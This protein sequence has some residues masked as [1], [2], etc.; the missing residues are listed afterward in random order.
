MR[1]PRRVTPLVAVAALI[2]GAL[3]LFGLDAL[4]G[5]IQVA[6]LLCCALAALIAMK[7]GHGFTA[8]EFL[9]PYEFPAADIAAA[10]K[11]HRLTQALF[12][13]P[14]GDW[15]KGERGLAALPGREADFAAA[16]DTA[17]HYAQ[18]L[19]CRRIHAMSG[20]ITSGADLSLMRRTYI[21]NLKRAADRTA[22]DGLTLCLEPINR[23]DIPGYFLNTTSEA[24]A[25]IGDAS[26][27]IGLTPSTKTRAGTLA[28]KA[29]GKTVSTNM[30]RGDG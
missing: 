3:A 29:T 5:P 21:D 17:R 13:L 19:E 8:V 11:R 10:L 15:G 2:A 14:P 23:R 25:I 4:D 7:N 28:K 9:F 1:N 22:K 18:A 27:N 20:L 24:A 12:N 30:R 6:L 16:L 26:N